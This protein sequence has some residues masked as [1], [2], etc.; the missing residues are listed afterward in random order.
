MAGPRVGVIGAGAWGCALA[1]VAAARGS[2][3]LWGRDPAAIA[4]IAAGEPAPRLGVGIDRSVRATAAFADLAACAVLVAAVPVSATAELCRRLDGWTPRPLVLAAKGLA[5]GGALLAD[6]VAAALAGWPV[7]LLSGPTFAAEVARGL[8]AAATLA[9]ADPGVARELAARLGRPGFRLYT[10][11]DMVGVGLGGAIKNVLAIAA[12]VVAGRGLGDNARAA[13]ITRGFA[14]L[15][16]YAR[17][18]GAEAATLGGLSGLGDLI[19][20]CS[21]PAS[22]NFAFGVALGEGADAATA[23]AAGRG[24]AEGAA[25]AP[26]LVAA[27]AAHGL[28][29]PIATAV[30]DLIAGTASVDAVIARL[31]DRPLRAEE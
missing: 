13:V 1:D 16:R 21:G 27:A 17:A 23:L 25:T 30:A 26:I 11:R 10:S 20:T 7:A 31:L 6:E 8:P 14:E 15:R 22:R 5:P 19:L 3:V 18:R 28:D 4:A 9:C 29:L 2:V 24:V 12:G